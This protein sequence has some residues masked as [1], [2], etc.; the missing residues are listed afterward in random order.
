MKYILEKCGLVVCLIW[1]LTGLVFSFIN[2]KHCFADLYIG[3][4]ILFTLL[5]LRKTNFKI[6]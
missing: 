5:L 6:N 2:L 3:L 1:L 4:G